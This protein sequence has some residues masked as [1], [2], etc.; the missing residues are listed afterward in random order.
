M[1][2]RE[3]ATSIREGITKTRSLG[4]RSQSISGKTSADWDKGQFLQV[5]TGGKKLSV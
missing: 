3:R 2:R 1:G 5:V 4:R